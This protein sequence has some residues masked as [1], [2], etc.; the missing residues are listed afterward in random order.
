MDRTKEGR[1]YFLK[2]T[3]TQVLLENLFMIFLKKQIQFQHYPS[4]LAEIEKEILA[5]SEDIKEMENF[6]NDYL[7]KFETL[8]NYSKRNEYEDLKYDLN[9]LEISYNLL[10]VCC[11]MSLILIK[12][13]LFTSFLYRKINLF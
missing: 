12:K 4:E 11:H 13:D 6:R 9:Q 3:I 2:F 8:R 10:Y 1:K 5:N 7:K